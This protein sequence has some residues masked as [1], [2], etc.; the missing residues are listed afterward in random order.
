MAN[1]KV[2]D[3][4]LLDS[5]LNGLALIIRAKT[6]STEKILFPT[7]F[8]AAVDEM[9]ETGKQSGYTDGHTAGLAEGKQAE[10]ISLMT[11]IQQ[12]GAKTNYASTFQSSYWTDDNFKPIFDM[13]VTGGTAMFK[14]SAITDLKGILERRGVTLDTS[15]CGN[16]YELMS[17]SKITHSPAISCLGVTVITQ[18]FYGC[19]DLISLKLILKADGTNTFSTPFAYCESLVDLVVEGVIGAKDFNLR[20]STKLSR[21]SIE[22][23]INALST[24]TTGL[25]VTLSKTAVQKA[26]ATE[27]EWNDFIAIRPNW[28]INLS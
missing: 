14:D 24:T 6:G 27:A 13:N 5:D 26:F 8:Y 21:A 16:V 17:G 3:A 20:W 9:F 2:V 12:G 1:Y 22:S 25:S 15:N 19:R 23:V 4:D 7:G 10:N 18:S 28:T 11:A